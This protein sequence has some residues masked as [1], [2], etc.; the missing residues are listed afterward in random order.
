MDF[1]QK[2]GNVQAASEESGHQQRVHA[3]RA[4]RRTLAA[5]TMYGLDHAVARTQIEENFQELSRVLRLGGRLDLAVADGNILVNGRPAGTND[6]HIQELAKTLG[7]LKLSDLGFRSGLSRQ[8]YAEL[9]NIF[10]HAPSGRP[11]QERSGAEL[12]RRKQLK[13]VVL[14]G[15]TY[16]R[17]AG[18]Q[19]IVDKRPGVTPSRHPGQPA[20]CPGAA[21]RH[22]FE[23]WEREWKRQ[24]ERGWDL[25]NQA[26][27]GS[28]AETLPSAD[29]AP[30]PV[31]DL[32]SDPAPAP[33]E[34]PA[35]GQR[36][37]GAED[38]T[39]TLSR[40]EA[41]EVQALLAFLGGEGETEGATAATIFA[42]SRPDPR[43]LGDLVLRAA[44]AE[45][46]RGDRGGE[47]FTDIV[48]ACLNRA[49]E[50]LRQAP[51]AATQKGRKDALQAMAELQQEV[52]DKLATL[53]VPEEEREV[54]AASAKT[55][56]NQLLMEGLAA[57]Y[58]KRRRAID[59]SEK[60]ILRLLRAKEVHDVQKLEMR[61]LLAEA[62]MDATDWDALA[63]R[64]KTPR[65]QKKASE[66]ASDKHTLV[67]HLD[68]LA[69]W[70]EH[71]EAEG[72]GPG[73]ESALSD[74][75][76]E[77]RRM[78]WETDEKIRALAAEREGDEAGPHAVP[79]RRRI[80]AGVADIVHELG[81]PVQVVACSNELL[82]KG[83]AGE[84]SDEQRR[85]LELVRESI[86]RMRGLM[87]KLE[88]LGKA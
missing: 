44:V 24:M 2:K 59:Q 51:D 87:E 60:R 34:T 37:A 55:L 10:A 16:Q 72:R 79:S 71:P 70:L 20:G 77:I 56:K 40:R 27:S 33:A 76:R 14:Q 80:L 39:V 30:P 23:E 64:L 17:I 25:G 50:G 57:D 47:P 41:E 73:L 78:A 8:E 58:A 12:L 68:A 66:P 62:G 81:Q 52:M 1:P 46:G 6:P 69:A 53:A 67:R 7:R 75:D 19:V 54:V 11:G 48:A 28:A 74:V 65:R 88:A 9:L 84:V 22:D 36:S 29:P 3:V 5:V 61:D 21:H 49:V 86:A 26:S 32:D 35:P 13:H 43:Q 63:S 4:F 85:L 31:I 42:R 83:C 18:D 45:L 38:V 15:G 82:L